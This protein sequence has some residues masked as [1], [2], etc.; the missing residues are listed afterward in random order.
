M[1]RRYA[2]LAASGNLSQVTEQV[3]VAAGGRHVIAARLAAAGVHVLAVQTADA[4]AAQLGRQGPG[5]ASV[6][7][8]ADAA[9]A[10][11]LAVG[12]AILGL[13]LSARRRR[14]EY[15]ALAASG[16]ARA[17]LRRSLLAEQL[18]VLGFGVAVG[19]GAGLAAAAI[20]L[21]DVPEFISQPQAF[22]LSY[23][24]AAG[25][26]AALLGVAAALLLAAA[27]LASA[28][29][30]RATSWA[31]SRASSSAS[32]AAASANESCSSAA[33]ASSGWSA[34]NRAA[35]PRSARIRTS[36]A[37]ASTAAR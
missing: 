5:L 9:A 29:L 14:Y 21:P 24:P 8:L 30:I 2:E 32:R 19:I 18:A 26:L 3:W 12:G 16:V 17:T 28:A 10:A 23:T 36:P 11:V 25:Q 27:A 22:P 37:R 33:A 4:V 31:A 20:A 35:S 15:A 7:F 6:L 13:Y 34:A 1:D